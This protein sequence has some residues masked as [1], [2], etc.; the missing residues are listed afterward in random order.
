M[1]AMCKIYL[2]KLANVT[3]KAGTFTV[4]DQ[5]LSGFVF[6]IYIIKLISLI[7]GFNVFA[8]ALERFGLSFLSAH[9]TTFF[10]SFA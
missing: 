3:F 7:C 8:N 5:L 1:F 9:S 10:F 4:L 6:I 2:L